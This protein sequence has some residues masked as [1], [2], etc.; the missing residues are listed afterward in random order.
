M[1]RENTIAV[2]CNT[3]SPTN[4]VRKVIEAAK[5]EAKD[6]VTAKIAKALESDDGMDVAA[7]IMGMLNFAIGEAAETFP[8]ST[9]VIFINGKETS[10][11]QQTVL[12]VAMPGWCKRS[13]SEN[14]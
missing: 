10:M 5:K 1:E 9:R 14:C 4:R 8:K 12:E 3:D 7:A 2:E 11:L 6:A 13:A